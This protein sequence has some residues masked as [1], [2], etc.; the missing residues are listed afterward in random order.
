MTA[1]AFTSA[2]QSA[3]AA[4]SGDRNPLH[5]DP[6]AARRLLFGR[7]IVHGVHA[8]LRALDECF[9]GA[10]DPAELRRVKADFHAG[11]GIDQ[12]VELTCADRNDRSADVRLEIE[13]APVMSIRAEWAAARPH[14][15]DPGVPSRPEAAECRDRSLDDVV[16]ASGS[17]PLHFDPEKAAGLF[18]N[19]TRCLPHD[20]LSILLGT[21]RLVGM[22]C[23]GLHSI[24]SGLDLAFTPDRSGPPELAY[25]VGHANRPLGLLTIEVRAP[26]T[27][28]RLSAFY[29]PKP[30]AQPPFAA[31]SR[32][33]EPGEFS[34]QRALVVG[35]SRG[36][37]EVAAKILA[38]GGAEVVITYQRG[39]QDARRVVA[40]LNAHGAKADCRRLDVL[41]PPRPLGPAVPGAHALYPLYL[42]Y[43]ATPPIFGAAKGRFSARRFEQFSRYYV[44]GFLRTARALIASGL[45]KVFYPSSAAVDELPPDM[46]E[47][48]AAKAAGEVA[49]AFLQKTNSGLAVHMPRL[50][51]AATDQTAGLL[52]VP[53][54]DPVAVLLGPLRRLR[55]MEP[56][57]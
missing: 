33:V 14:P 12:A 37:G 53:S 2:E 24:Y 49:C 56:P 34:G 47:Y 5:V 45:S 51:R 18:P 9:T 43:F 55:E 13:G 17:V 25:R 7:Q 41:E 38:A 27:S 39:E 28:G 3:F 1:R 21:T 40:E 10:A 26:G 11:I 52:P 35:G 8:L 6:V 29:R 54:R 46:G 31:I 15:A 30:Q 36:L 32:H 20:Q 22:E 4:L 16:A 57:R 44:A 50:P 23:P 48:A 19:L 42:Y